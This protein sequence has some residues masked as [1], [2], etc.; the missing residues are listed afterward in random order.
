MSQQY[1]GGIITKNA[2]VP[3]GPYQDSSASGVWTLDQ[4]S[5]YVKAGNWPTFGNANP[6][7]F[8]ENLFST[9]L[10]TG[11]GT[12]QTITNGID[13]ST[14]G[15]MVWM[16]C[17]STVADHALYDTA[18][19][20]TRDLASNT[21]TAQTTQA[22]GLTA[23]TT[24]GFT[25]GS[26]AKINLNA[27]TFAA[28]TFREQPKFFDIVTWTGN[29]ANRT[30]PHNL[31]SV[32]GCIIVKRTSSAA[33]WTVYHRSLANTQYL[34][35]DS[36]L[37]AITDATVWN[38]TTPTST[39]FSVG[40]SSNV[41][42]NTFTYVAYLFAHN[43]GG[44]GLTGT[45]NVISCG[46]YTGSASA[47][48]SVTLGWEPQWLL[49][50][51]TD[52]TSTGDWYIFDNMRGVVT[53][54]SEQTLSANTTAIESN[55]LGDVIDFNATGFVATGTTGNLNS[56]GSPY[57]YIAIRRGPMKVPTSGTSVFSPVARS[58][59]SATATITA[60]GF[61]PDSVWVKSRSD[62]Y[63]WYDW[64]KLRGVPAGR[65]QF[66]TTGAEPGSSFDIF[67]AF[68]NT[69]YTLGPDTA[70][71]QVNASGSTYINY[72]LGRAPGFMDVVC[73]TGTGANRT[74]NHNLTVVPELIIVKGRDIV[75]PWEVYC[76]ALANTQYL[77]LNT[78]AAVATGA[79]RW[80]STTPTSAVFSLG[81]STQLNTSGSTYV[82]YLFATAPG[83]SKVGSYT[84][85]GTTQVI[86]CGFTAGSRFVMI[87]RT[88]STGDWYVWDS[89]R[90]I[91]AGN[92]PYLLL[93]STAAEVTS[94]D[95]IDTA[96][97]G[98][99]ISSTAPAAINANGGSF[100]FLAIA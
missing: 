31:G 37:A 70:S 48:T 15:G 96:A 5:Q 72:A 79:T 71:S 38:S 2:V 42:A 3:S 46:S 60:P 66:N 83:V 26:L 88:N 84:G 100:I 74:I 52:S 39:E 75:A 47:T 92:D 34:A 78:T 57:I 63:G 97:T 17:R 35:L 80:N 40:T 21:T 81:T 58:G 14:N 33:S 90:G 50:K 1:P 64:D 27:S 8:I 28:W 67:T 10:Y 87:K 65:L 91:V 16:K 20:T 99:E 54:G 22:T 93:N 19:G 32:P 69:G 55:A 77:V 49:V 89:A 12:S 13:L 25:I 51:R 68:T 76:G 45:D 59:T 18:R 24:S 6:N 23:F 36:T 98:F 86:N 43:A 7:L 29:G 85:T 30:I 11:N 4:A 44:F 41:N 61:A 9:W 95:Y 53:G 56:S 82:A 62:A 73:Y 94:T